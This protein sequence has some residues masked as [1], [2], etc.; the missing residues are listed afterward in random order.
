MD[1]KTFIKRTTGAA[2]LAIP[3]YALL[4]C[5]NDDTTNVPEPE[6]PSSTDCLANGANA[7]SISS[8]HGH[9]LAVSK[10]D[11]EAGVAKTYSIQGTSGHNH[12]VSLTAANF[13][14]LKSTK[15]LVIESSRDSSHRHDVTVSCA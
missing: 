6:N 2:L 4:G 7:T 9:T 10:D 15:T 1:R 14:T 8:N 12:S 11:I 3:A 13:E 5:S